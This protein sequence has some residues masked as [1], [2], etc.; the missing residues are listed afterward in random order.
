MASIFTGPLP[1]FLIISSCL[2]RLEEPDR[3]CS[4]GRRGGRACHKAIRVIN[5]E[6]AR[7]TGMPALQFDNLDQRVT[8][9]AGI[10]HSHSWAQDRTGSA[11][12]LFGSE[13]IV[14]TRINCEYPM[15]FLH[16]PPE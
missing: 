9:V 10:R 2:E 14:L 6:G 8:R 11:Y 1:R 12:T 3:A 7:R 13:L 4:K 15:A 5:V 16:G